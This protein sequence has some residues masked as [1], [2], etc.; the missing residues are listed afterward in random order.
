MIDL[1][2]IRNFIEKFKNTSIEKEK[3]K[4]EIP[5]DLNVTNDIRIKSLT[6]REN[7][8]FLLLLEGYTLKESA[9]L[10][11]IKYSTANTHINNI[12]KKLS[13]KS[14]AE[15]IIKYVNIKSN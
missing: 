10:L 7:E 4:I 9:N 14:R 3:V 11:N 12:Y 1:K 13:V 6:P 8:L 15:L 2:L 5:L